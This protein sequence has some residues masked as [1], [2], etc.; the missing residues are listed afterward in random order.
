MKKIPSISSPLFSSERKICEIWRKLHRICHFHSKLNDGWLSF[1]ISRKALLTW[2]WAKRR[3][4]MNK[5]LLPWPLHSSLAALCLR[6]TG[7][8]CW[9]FNE[10]SVLLLSVYWISWP[11]EFVTCPSTRSADSVPFPPV[12]FHE[13]PFFSGLKRFTT[14]LF[15]S[16]EGNKA[17][18]HLLTG[19]NLL[20]ALISV[21]CALERGKCMKQNIRPK[22]L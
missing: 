8:T 14:F 17:V 9:P 21:P 4:S 19:G 11:L 22:L 20:P 12:N 1:T 16:D 10:W 3:N 15:V 5:L 2:T 7:A 13:T 18:K 6:V